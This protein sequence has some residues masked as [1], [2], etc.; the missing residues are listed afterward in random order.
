MPYRQAVL[1]I[2]YGKNQED[3]NQRLATAIKG[4]G[5]DDDCGIL[6]NVRLIHVRED[7]RTVFKQLAAK[8]SEKDGLIVAP[9]GDKWV[10]QNATNPDDCGKL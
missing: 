7:L 1:V 6:A 4:S 5:Y 3:A 9:L 2:I 8:V 10:G